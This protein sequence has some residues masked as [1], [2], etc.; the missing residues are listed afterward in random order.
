MCYLRSGLASF[1]LNVDSRES[2]TDEGLKA[3]ARALPSR[4]TNV[5]LRSRYFSDEGLKVLVRLLPG[6]LANFS[7]N[8][9]GCDT[10]TDK[11]L[12]ALE[13][14]PPSGLARASPSL[15]QCPPEGRRRRSRLS[16]SGRTYGCC[17]ASDR[18]YGYAVES[19]K[20]QVDWSYAADAL[21]FYRR[22]QRQC[23]RRA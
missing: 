4:L 15:P 3:L 20:E 18:T 17:E 16:F 6:G 14:G 21:H 1:S 12:K 19:R 5:S 9:K 2:L 11:G 10:I 13:C 22:R 8:L 7:L 23:G